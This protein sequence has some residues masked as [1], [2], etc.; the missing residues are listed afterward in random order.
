MQA[1]VKVHSELT[2][3]SGLQP[4]GLPIYS[5]RQEQTACPFTCLHWLFGP[6]GEGLQGFLGISTLAR[7]IF[8]YFKNLTT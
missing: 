6:H 5:G 1:F 2:V 4:G 7:K 8:D 3:H